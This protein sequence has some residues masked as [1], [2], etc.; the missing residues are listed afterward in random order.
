M[1]MKKQVKQS[2]KKLNTWLL[3]LERALLVPLVWSVQFARVN[4][5]ETIQH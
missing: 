5:T 4:M 1:I 2:I 3:V